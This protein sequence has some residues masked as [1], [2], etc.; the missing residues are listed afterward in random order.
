M[1]RLPLTMEH[2]LLG[3]LRERPRHGYDIHQLL[4][5]PAGLGAIWRLKQ[6]Q[7]YA[8]LAKLETDGFVASTLKPQDTR[9]TRKVFRLTKTGREAFLAWVQSP[10]PHGR[11]M[12][13]DFLAKFYFAR[14]EGREVAGQLIELQ[15]ATCR[16][17]LE[18]QRAQ[19]EALRDS[20]LDEW[21]VHRFRIGQ[22]EAILRWLETCEQTLSA[23]TG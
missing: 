19:A 20:H 6:S 13:L 21:I 22:L 23:S 12:R 2:A 16:D 7:L 17:W 10:V 4:S 15:R 5:D 1:I 11:E 8:L 9:P 14:R 3:L 18:A